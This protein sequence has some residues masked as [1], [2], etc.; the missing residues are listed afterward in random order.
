VFLDTASIDSGRVWPDAIRAALD[1]ADVVLV[2]IG[3]TT[4]LKTDEYGRRLIDMET[5]WVRREVARA[6]E[7]QKRV[8]PVLVGGARLPPASVLPV[9]L[10][11]LPD[12]QE[13]VLRN[14][15]WDTDVRLLVEDVRQTLVALKRLQTAPVPDGLASSAQPRQTV[16]A[17]IVVTKRKWL[18]GSLTVWLL[19]AVAVLLIFAVER[20]GLGL[21]RDASLDAP[22]PAVGN[23]ECQAGDRKM[24]TCRIVV[25]SGSLQLRFEAPTATAGESLVFRGPLSCVAGTCSGIM[26]R[27]F[28]NEEPTPAGKISLSHAA[29]GS[30]S[31]EWIENEHVTA[32]ALS[33][34]L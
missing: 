7:L 15:R 21:R 10:H 29:N 3:P 32:F 30:W 14:E 13:F 4:L 22:V 26:Q 34:Q 23:Y 2:V 6:L 5:D 11:T 1:A 20:V 17:P 12:R 31:G 18:R 8:I 16:A 27:A 25:N 28:E 9:S 33:P 24:T 19:A